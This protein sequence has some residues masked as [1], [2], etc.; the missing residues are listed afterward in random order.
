M[1]NHDLQK[2]NELKN[3]LKSKIDQKRVSRFTKFKR[4][5]IVENNMKKLEINNQEKQVE[6][7]SK[8]ES[9][10]ESKV[11]IESK[12]EINVDTE[13]YEHYDENEPKIV[14]IE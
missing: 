13:E 2:R 11:E 10:A 6:N 1:N 8:T 7:E 5:T 14:E 3:K 12:T 9:N 4:N